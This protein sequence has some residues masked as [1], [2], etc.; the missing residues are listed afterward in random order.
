MKK[1]IFM[2]AAAAMVVACE[3]L[4]QNLGAELGDSTTEGTTDT[5]DDTTTD[6][7]V[8]ELMFTTQINALTKVTDTNFESGDV[9]AVT[10]YDASGTLVSDAAQYTHNGSLFM[11][12]APIVYSG[13]DVTYSFYAVYPTVS[14]LQTSLDFYVET[15]QS[16]ASA[17][18]ASDLLVASVSSSDAIPQLSF[19]H[20][21]SSIV[22]NIVGDVSGEATFSAK[23]G[24][25][26]GVK[27]GSMSA[28]G[29]ATTVTPLVYSDSLSMSCSVILAPQT[30]AM[31]STLAT[32]TV[33]SLV[34]EWV[35]DTD[36]DMVSGKQYMFNWS[37]ADREVTLVS[38]INGWD[39]VD[40]GTIESL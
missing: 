28:L 32:Y 21:M 26:Y 9:I 20:K 29:S 36:F 15:D 5:T 8:T 31:G 6:G 17:F 25:R 10:A 13:D 7:T 35:L 4:E 24:L 34:Y 23:S 33:G 30:V 1:I 37:L 16:S 18:T 39:V 12:S 11:S 14:S 22:I 19:D 27:T 38:V 40:G 2:L 3:E